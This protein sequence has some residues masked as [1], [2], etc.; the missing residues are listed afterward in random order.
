MTEAEQFKIW[1]KNIFKGIRLRKEGKWTELDYQRNMYQLAMKFEL[2]S[3]DIFEYETEIQI[4]KEKAD[5]N[6]T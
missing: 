2:P 4:L 3:S 1:I 6:R 5:E